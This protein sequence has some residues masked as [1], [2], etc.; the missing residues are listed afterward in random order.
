MAIVSNVLI[1]RTK[2]SVGGT[3]F[4]KW[5]DKNVLSAKRGK[6]TT[7]ATELQA[8]Q[9]TFFS[10]YSTLA[11]LVVYMIAIGFKRLATSMTERNYFMKLNNDIQRAQW[12]SGGNFDLSFL[13]VSKGSLPTFNAMDVEVAAGNT[14][15]FTA[16][17]ADR[18]A[19]A[20]TMYNLRIL[21]L[22]PNG[23]QVL[24]SYETELSDFDAISYS[25]VPTE[26]VQVGTYAFA[27]Y[28]RKGTYEVCDSVM[29]NVAAA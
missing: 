9:Q 20:A 8:E 4:K 17:L 15:N 2:Q 27:Y 22:N 24:G 18:P 16:T 25:F 28:Y 12:L 5:K 14:I 3:T 21:I 19:E 6:S 13:K 7:P 11:K 29:R 26:T 1:G 10:A 23:T